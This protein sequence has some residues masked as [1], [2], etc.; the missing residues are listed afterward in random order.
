MQWIVL[1][2]WR[3]WDEGGGRGEEV[4]KVESEASVYV[5]MYIVHERVLL[6]WWHSGCPWRGAAISTGSWYSVRPPDKWFFLFFYSIYLPLSAARIR[7]WILS[8]VFF[9][10]LTNFCFKTSSRLFSFS[11]SLSLHHL[12]PLNTLINL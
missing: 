4:A 8:P 5:Y 12:T 2:G 10:T 6:C 1:G 9:Y 3:W 11:L 7:V